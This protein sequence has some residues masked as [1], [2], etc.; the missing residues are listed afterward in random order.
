MSD[1]KNLLNEA[2]ALFQQA[3]NATG[4]HADDLRK[5]AEALL[6]KAKVSAQAFQED[7]VGKSKEA[8]RATDEYV[9]TNPWKAVGL[10]AGIGLLLGLLLNRDK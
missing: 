2:E 6:A 10:A 5:K 1:P 7:V 9:Q 4:V 8:A 3:A